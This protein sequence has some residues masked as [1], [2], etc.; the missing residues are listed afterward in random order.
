MKTIEVAAG[1]IWNKGRFLAARRYGCRHGAGFW[2]FP[3]GKIEAGESAEQALRRELAEELGLSAV[4]FSFWKT[5]EHAYP[6]YKVV[7]HFFH[8]TAYR[9]HPALIEGHDALAWI[10]PTDCSDYCFLPA[11][12]QI[13]MELQRDYPNGPVEKEAED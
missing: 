13:L 2:E 11:D 10:C 8:V 9:N 6:D 5:E 7:L 3:G 4:S 1:V 12:T